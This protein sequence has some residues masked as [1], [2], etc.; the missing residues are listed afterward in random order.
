MLAE[1]PNPRQVPNDYRRRWFNDETFDLIVWFAD[2][3]DIVGFEL[4]YRLL[5]FERALT[6]MEDRGY[7]HSDV[8]TGDNRPASYGM[9]PILT[10]D[11]AFDAPRIADLFKHAAAKLDPEIRQ[12]VLERLDKYPDKSNM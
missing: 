9:T 8:D 6:W 1:V 2:D 10:P 7:R 5:G 12:F 11:G 3:N 4:C